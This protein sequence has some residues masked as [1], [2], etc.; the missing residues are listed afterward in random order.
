MMN[1]ARRVLK[2]TNVFE[3]IDGFVGFL[4]VAQ[5]KLIVFFDLCFRRGG[6]LLQR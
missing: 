2:K 5:P 6:E 3:T 1:N 4:E